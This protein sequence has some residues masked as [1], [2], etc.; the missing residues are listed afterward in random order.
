MKHI[1]MATI[2]I[3]ML[4]SSVSGKD[5]K[6]R[7]VDMEGSP[8]E[9]VNAVLLQDSTF[10]IGTITNSNGEFRLSS[11]ITTGLILRLSSIGYDTKFVDIPLDGELGEIKMTAANFQMNGVVVRG[12]ASKTYL[13]GSSLVTNVENS[14]LANAGTA[15]D[16]LRQIPMIVENNGN[17]EVFGKGVPAIYINGRKVS[18][19]QE[20]STLLSGGIRNVEIVTNPGASYSADAKAVIRIRTKKPQGD[21]WSGTLRITNGFQHYYQSANMIDLKYRTRGL[22][23]FSNLTYNTGKNQEKKTTDITTIAKSKWDQKL[24]TFNARRYDGIWGKIGF[25]WMIDNNHSIGA[26]YQNEYGKN[27]T[28]S[29]LTSS[30]LENGSFYDKWETKA[31]NRKKNTPRHAVNVYYNG[32]IKKFNVDFNVDYVWNKG[33]QRSVNNEVSQMQDNQYVATHSINKNG[34]L[35]EK[36]V[37]SY[38]LGKGM[39]RFGEEYISSNTYNHFDTEYSGLNNAISKIKEDNAACFIEIMPQIGKFSFGAGLRYEHVDYDYFEAVSSEGN[40][41]RTYDNMFPSL[42]IATHLGKVQMSLSYSGRMERPTY[43]NLNANI[44]YLNRMTYES[45][46]PRLQPTQIQSLE[47]LAVWKNY[48]VQVSYSYFDNPIVTTTKP[49]SDDGEITILTY[50]NFK[51]KHFLQAF[52]GSQFK[53]GVWQPRVNIGIFT[54]WFDILVDDRSKSMNNPIGILQWQN[55]VHLPLDIWLNIDGQWTTAGNDRNI[56]LSSSSYIN[57]KLYKDFCKKKL[58]VTLELRD[59]FNGSRPDFTF[60]NNAVT[61]F[62]RNYSEMCSVMFTLQYNFNVTRDRYRGTGAGNTEKKRF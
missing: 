6:G 15:K 34:M 37:L 25:S 21:G 57:V 26:Y 13:R 8:L 44:S 16:V 45:G 3:L 62:Q 32:Q 58:G 52:M 23:I 36:L 14:V 30:I 27:T 31:D 40:L 20:L 42:N 1:I 12:N 50:D 59:I 18:D 24:N 55:A 38:P 39:L 46:N 33:V 60:Y 35:A 51:K 22:E 41:S 11:D 2:A 9:F 61:M 4:S 29:H 43:S 54:Q 19:P 7:A 53:V 48:F 47:Y 10:T 28:K 49:Y 56:H 5:I 17:I